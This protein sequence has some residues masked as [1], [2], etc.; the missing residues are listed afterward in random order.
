MWWGFT[1]ASAE[2][3]APSHAQNKGGRC[4]FTPRL[5]FVNGAVFTAPLPD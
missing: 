4:L 1:T 2:P 3:Y 5:M